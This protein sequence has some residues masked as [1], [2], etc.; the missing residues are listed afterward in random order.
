[1]VDIRFEQD[2]V[3]QH[4]RN[5]N[6]KLTQFFIDTSFGMVKTP[7]Q[8][9]V[10]QIIVATVLFIFS[11]YMFAQSVPKATPRTP[12]QELIDSPQPTQP[13]VQ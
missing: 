8:A 5:R 10:A 12:T 3:V 6:T 4:Y 9:R 2:A 7:R 11:S 13:L 1:M